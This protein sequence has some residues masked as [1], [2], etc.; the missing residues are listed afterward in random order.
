MNCP[1]TYAR[2]LPMLSLALPLLAHSGPAT[3]YGSQLPSSR[4]SYAELPRVQ[5]LD[6]PRHAITAQ[7]EILI[8]PADADAS[9]KDLGVCTRNSRNAWASVDSLVTPGYTLDSYE[10]RFVGSS[11]K[12]VLLLYWRKAR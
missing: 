11:G 9:W 12:Q 7:G 8:C 6:T 10:F 4:V 1:T 3:Q 2:L 5:V